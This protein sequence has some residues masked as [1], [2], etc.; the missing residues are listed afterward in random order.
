MLHTLLFF[1]FILWT[2][3]TNPILATTARTQILPILSK[4]KKGFLFVGRAVLNSLIWILTLSYNMLPEEQKKRLDC[5]MKTRLTSLNTLMSAVCI[6]L[7]AL[8]ALMKINQREIREIWRT[9]WN[10]N[11]NTE[12]RIRF[13][14]NEEKAKNLIN[15]TSRLFFI[16]FLLIIT[17]GTRICR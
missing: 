4:I 7:S 8:I 2:F 1:V 9:F 15:V 10:L 14:Q 5:A 13:T 17:E 6:S 3:Q 12:Q 11:A 16:Y